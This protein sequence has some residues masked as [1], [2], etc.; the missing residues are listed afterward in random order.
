MAN[1]EVR[2]AQYVYDIIFSDYVYSVTNWAAGQ[3]QQTPQNIAD[4]N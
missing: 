4:K 3:K 1:S 2:I